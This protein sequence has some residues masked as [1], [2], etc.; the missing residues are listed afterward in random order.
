MKE[1]RSELFHSRFPSGAVDV[2]L[3]C[4]LLSRMHWSWIPLIISHILGEIWK[5]IQQFDLFLKQEVISLIS[6]CKSG[7]TTTPKAKA[8]SRGGYL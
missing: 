5:Q 3:I 1:C 6:S 2:L 4:Y 7:F 8:D